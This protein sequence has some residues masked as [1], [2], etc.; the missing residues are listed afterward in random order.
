MRVP[1][2]STA[3][4]C[5]ILDQEHNAILQS[6]YIPALTARTDT[7]VYLC[8]HSCA[9]MQT[10]ARTQ[11]RPQ[12]HSFE[13]LPLYTTPRVAAVRALQPGCARTL[14]DYYRSP[15]RGFSPAGLSPTRGFRP[16]FH[17]RV[18]CQRRCIQIFVSVHGVASNVVRRPR[19]EGSAVTTVSPAASAKPTTSWFHAQ[20]FARALTAGAVRS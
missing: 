3:Y 9:P 11:A 4:E 12:P 1:Y 18:S 6:V 7:A 20:P 2:L 19:S 16:R 14:L 13:A 5:R 10:H 8:R 17:R 15:P